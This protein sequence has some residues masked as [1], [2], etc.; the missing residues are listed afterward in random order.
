MSESSDTLDCKSRLIYQVISNG[1]NY[2]YIGSDYTSP[3]THSIFGL[4]VN[5]F[6]SISMTT[7]MSGNIGEVYTFE[8]ITPS[9]NFLVLSILPA[10]QGLYEFSSAFSLKAG[11]LCSTAGITLSWMSLNDDYTYLIVFGLDSNKKTIAKLANPVTFSEITVTNTLDLKFEIVNSIPSPSS[12]TQF[13]AL[14]RDSITYRMIVTAFVITASPPCLAGYVNYYN[15]GCFLPITSPKCHPLCTTCL[16][17]NNPDACTEA[18]GTAELT[19]FSSS[20]PFGQTFDERSLSCK[21]VITV[22]CDISCKFQCF[23]ANDPNSCIPQCHSGQVY[24]IS[25]NNCESNYFYE[26]I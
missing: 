6:N 18:S 9:G 17:F 8:F 22:S 4:I 15:F 3:G 19:L 5:S 16:V 24:N 25:T 23:A 2:A 10:S 14:A 7:T 21:T 26:N 1:G 11:P 12:T 20:C 13:I